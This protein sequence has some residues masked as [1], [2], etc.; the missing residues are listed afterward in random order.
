MSDVAVGLSLFAFLMLSYWLV[1][2]L[3]GDA[4]RAAAD[5]RTTRSEYSSTGTTTVTSHAS[6]TTG[7]R[8]HDRHG[9]VQ[10]R[11]AAGEQEATVTVAPP[12]SAAAVKPSPTVDSAIVDI[13]LPP[14]KPLAASTPYEAPPA[15]ATHAPAAQQQ[16]FHEHAVR[17]HAPVSTP[18]APHAPAA[19]TVESAKPAARVEAPIAPPSAPPVT[20][21]EV[22]RDT[23]KV[24]PAAPAAPATQSASPVAT[25]AAATAAATAAA[26]ALAKSAA[27]A[28]A[29]T[30]APA[31]Q[32][33]SAPLQAAPVQAA[34]VQAAQAPTPAPISTP[35]ATAPAPAATAAAVSGT[36]ADARATLPPGYVPPAP[37][38][39]AKPATALN[40]PLPAHYQR[41][42]SAA[43]IAPPMPAPQPM[44]T[45]VYE[46]LPPLKPNVISAPAPSTGPSPV[47]PPRV[48][49]TLP[50]N[51]QAPAPVAPPAKFSTAAIDLPAHFARGDWTATLSPEKRAALPPKAPAPAAPA[52]APAVAARPAP[53]QAA[54]AAAPVA[55]APA[56]AAPAA[57]PAKDSSTDT[58]SA[59]WYAAQAAATVTATAVAAAA[60]S[61]APA[62]TQRDAV[63]PYTER[64]SSLPRSDATPAAVSTAAVASI[65]KPAEPEASGAASSPSS[66]SPGLVST[67]R[68]GTRVVGADADDAI[69]LM[70]VGV[71]RPQTP[72][73]WDSTKP[74]RALTDDDILAAEILSPSGTQSIKAE[75][76]PIRSEPLLVRPDVSRTLAPAVTAKPAAAPAAATP[77]PKPAAEYSALKP[78][79]T[80]IPLVSTASGT[81]GGHAISQARMGVEPP[82][83]VVIVKPSV[84]ATLPPGALGED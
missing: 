41:A 82:K 49:G 83:P 66:S 70:N 31:T 46:P 5:H 51:Y 52:A 65:S 4:R 45:P 73:I 47:L 34:S 68:R 75:R 50:A 29:S 59:S 3:G 60:A 39:V 56:A 44:P 38:A 32:P 77:A 24:A 9:G 7:H 35:A 36:R 20:R 81:S 1:R 10:T 74:R 2:V 84:N 16:T 69:D 54:V 18:A 42:S 28:A 57:S 80:D 71:P 8:V 78:I 64:A 6:E 53:A 79:P 61:P 48:Q 30:P 15:P 27:P 33:Q 72:S 37:Q 40:E 26:V 58:R 43:T 55:R 25:V 22:I 19:V 12:A 62:A 67:A 11:A 13:A 14:Q 63:S 17:T 76:I 23:P 21:V